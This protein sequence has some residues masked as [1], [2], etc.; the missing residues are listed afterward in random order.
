MKNK[1]LV[2]LV[3]IGSMCLCG[4][5]KKKLLVAKPETS[6]SKEATVASTEKETEETTTKKA[7]SNKTTKENET[8]KKSKEKTTKE[9]TTKAS[10]ETTTAKEKTT[11]SKK[12]ET[13]A[14]HQMPIT[15]HTVQRDD[16]SIT[17]ENQKTI[18]VFADIVTVDGP[19]ETL[20]R[21]INAE[22]KELTDAYFEKNNPNDFVYDLQTHND[23]LGYSLAPMAIASIYYNEEY[24]SIGWHQ[25]WY[26]GGVTNNLWKSLNYNAKTGE[27]LTIYELLGDNAKQLI[28]DKL[29]EV[30]ELDKTITTEALAD[31]DMNELDFYL[32]DKKI[33][34]AFDSYEIS[35]GTS[36]IVIDFDRK[37]F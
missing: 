25:F 28:L 34:I 4:C 16:R 35:Q 13:T 7:S 10:K 12:K 23:S 36:G 17:L 26:A 30:Y 21:K 27:K 22:V 1:K 18:E 5:A 2:T 8:T 15:D 9:T 37:M 24:I 6:S 14:S 31:Y 33:Y 11:S 3:L 32:D 19:N 29:L 20:V